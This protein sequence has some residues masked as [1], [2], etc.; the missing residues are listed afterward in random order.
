MDMNRVCHW[1]GRIWTLLKCIPSKT[2]VNEHC[3]FR[4]FLDG[5]E[6]LPTNYHVQLM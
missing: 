3:E 2:V 4:R 6:K 1:F 5:L